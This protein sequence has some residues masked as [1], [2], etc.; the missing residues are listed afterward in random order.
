MGRELIQRERCWLKSMPKPTRCAA[1]TQPV[2]ARLVWRSQKKA[3]RTKQRVDTTEANLQG[4]PSFRSR[5]PC[6]ADDQEVL[7]TRCSNPS[8]FFQCDNVRG[9]LQQLCAL[10]SRQRESVC[11]G[12]RISKIRRNVPDM[13]LNSDFAVAS[14]PTSCLRIAGMHETTY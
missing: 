5:H 8:G 10:R 14:E 1:V 4:A 11:E 2:S 7:S 9:K 6:R 13:H 12:I 3:G